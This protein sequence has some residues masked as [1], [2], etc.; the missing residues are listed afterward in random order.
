MVALCEQRSRMSIYRGSTVAPLSLV[1]V[2]VATVGRGT[3]SQCAAGSLCARTTL[4]CKP[5]THMSIPCACVRISVS[6]G[7]LFARLCKSVSAC[8][9]WLKIRSCADNNRTPGLVP[10][11]T[12]CP[13]IPHNP[14]CLRA[15]DPCAS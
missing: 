1:I 13:L 9:S 15:G 6:A 14:P 11:H 3:H 12:E 10:S 8:V 4:Q 2:T 5:R 7:A